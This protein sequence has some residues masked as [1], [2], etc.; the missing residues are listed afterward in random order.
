MDIEKELRKS[1]DEWEFNVYQL[2]KEIPKGCVITYG[3]LAK[4]TNARFGLNINPRNVAN[5]RRKLYGLL[6]HDTDIPLHRIA[7]QGDSKSKYDR[8]ETQVY[9]QRL[10][11]AE[12]SWPEPTWLYE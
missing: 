9:N 1:K 11:S 5:L 3:G 2:I 10:R 6:T 8:P 12:G 4:R 7:K